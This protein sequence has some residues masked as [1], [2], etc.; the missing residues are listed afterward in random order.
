MR[1]GTAPNDIKIVSSDLDQ[2]ISVM[3]G[4]SPSTASSLPLFDKRGPA[5]GENVNQEDIVALRIPV[6][7]PCV[8]VFKPGV[9]ILIS[10]AL[11]EALAARGTELR[12]ADKNPDNKNANS[13]DPEKRL[14]ML[15][16]ARAQ[17][18]LEQATPSGT[19]ENFQLPV[20]LLRDA[21]YLVG[22]LLENGL[23]EVVYYGSR[24]KMMP[25]A[26]IK[27]NYVGS[28]AGPTA[29]FGFIAFSPV[30]GEGFGLF[31]FLHLDSWSS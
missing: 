20:S 17:N 30:C 23:A 28:R 2:I 29:G 9:D 18:I 22:Q 4:I 26:S 31:E 21:R 14:Q 5:T 12:H 24:G 1:P 19:G 25:A 11:L 6:A 13:N 8:A 27:V 15:R 3:A 16:G 10:R 7:R